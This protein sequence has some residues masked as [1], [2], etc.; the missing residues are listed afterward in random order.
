[1]GICE[2]HRGTFGL[3][4]RLW[5]PY[6][7]RKRLPMDDHMFCQTEGSKTTNPGCESKERSKQEGEPRASENYWQDEGGDIQC[8][9]SKE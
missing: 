3:L 9:K 1:M 2:G 6:P 5:R 7:S 8:C 4:P